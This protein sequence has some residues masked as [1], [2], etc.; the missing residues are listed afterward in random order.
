MEKKELVAATLT[1]ILLLSI[2]MMPVSA[3]AENVPDTIST[4]STQSVSPRWKSTRTVVPS[5]TVSGKKISV[6]VY[7]SPISSTTTTKG[8]LY[9]E[10]KNKNG[11]T[12]IISWPIDSTGKVNMTKSYHGTAGVTY[13]ARVIVTTGADKIDTV[14][15]ER[16]V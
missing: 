11:W 7:I 9:L 16:T 1:I 5:I 10:K 4:I 13:R 6:S 12:S 8:K 15:N 3:A 14:S 2:H